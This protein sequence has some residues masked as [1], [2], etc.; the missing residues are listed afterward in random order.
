MGTPPNLNPS[1]N[2]IL[3]LTLVG[4]TSLAVGRNH[5]YERS[6]DIRERMKEGVTR[7]QNKYLSSLNDYYEEEEWPDEDDDMEL[8]YYSVPRRKS[9]MG[10]RML[11][12][13][14]LITGKHG[15]AAGDNL[16]GAVPFFGDGCAAGNATNGTCTECNDQ[17][18]LV[19]GSCNCTFVYKESTVR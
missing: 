5:P 8:E 14:Y 13:I 2:S 11:D 1:R 7:K 3:V 16:L 10:K 9:D 19:N 18:T 15:I 12:S 4:L 17:S 6:E